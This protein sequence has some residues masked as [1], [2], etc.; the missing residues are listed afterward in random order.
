MR[1]A[2]CPVPEGGTR[3][4]DGTVPLSGSIGG[5]SIPQKFLHVSLLYVTVSVDLRHFGRLHYGWSTVCD[6]VSGL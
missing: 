4:N 6:E 3:E 2:T 1:S 5:C